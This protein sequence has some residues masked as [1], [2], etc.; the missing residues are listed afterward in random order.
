[1]TFCLQEGQNGAFVASDLRSPLPQHPSDQ[2]T[3]EAEWPWR[4]REGDV[5]VL[6]E[7]DI[8][9]GRRIRDYLRDFLGNEADAAD[10]TQEVLLKAFRGLRTYRPKGIALETWLLRIAKNHAL[11]I[12]KKRSRL[13]LQDPSA[14]EAQI[15]QDG[16]SELLTDDSEWLGDLTLAQSVEALSVRRREVLFLRYAGGLNASEIAIEL[17]MTPAAVRQEH[18][19]ALVALRSAMVATAGAD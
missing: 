6:E 17:G 13:I 18:H 2:S 3:G 5:A 14:I 16:L 8:R 11:D 12:V 19:R 10:A 7:L 15:E 4:A 9:F 1:M